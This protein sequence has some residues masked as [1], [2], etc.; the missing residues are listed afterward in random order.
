MI[1]VHDTAQRAAAASR[2]RVQERLSFRVVTQIED[3]PSFWMAE[4][5]HQRYLEKR[6]LA[7]CSVSLAH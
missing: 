3:G 5:S 7:S 2:D 4:D 6:G 1:F